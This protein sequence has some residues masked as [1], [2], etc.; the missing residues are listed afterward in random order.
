MYYSSIIY[1]KNLI[2]ALNCQF[3]QKK[4]NSNKN[5]FKLMYFDKFPSLLRLVTLFACTYDGHK[6]GVHFDEVKFAR[7]R[8]D[9]SFPP[10]FS[11]PPA[12]FCC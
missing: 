6:K 7:M 5:G 1:Y 9:V 10:Q 12:V 8:F 2:L 4:K 11:C 3:V